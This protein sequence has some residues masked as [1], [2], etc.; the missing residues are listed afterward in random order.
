[1][2]TV[3]IVPFP[4]A[5]GPQGEPGPAGPQGPAGT[6]ASFPAPISWTP[7]LSATGFTQSANP[8]TGNYIKYG[9]IVHV[10]L[11]VPLNNVTNFGTGQYSITLP[12]TSYQHTDIWA[13]TIHD[14]N[15]GSFYSIKGHIDANSSV[16]TLW[17]LS[18]ISKDEPFDFNSPFTLDN[19]DLFH[20]SFAYETVQ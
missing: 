14:T 8:A 19:T 16:M 20:M 10:N 15:T 17:Y 1:M 18:T 4:G 7:V 9:R 12:F 5:P 13:G 6:A 11:N 3:K 2:P